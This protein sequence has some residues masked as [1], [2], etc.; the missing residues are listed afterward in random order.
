MLALELLLIPR[1]CPSS[2]QIELV[3]MNAIV[4]LLKITI[5]WLFLIPGIAVNFNAADKKRRDEFLKLVRSF[6]DFDQAQFLLHFQWNQN[7]ENF[8]E[9]YLWLFVFDTPNLVEVLFQLAGS[10]MKL[11]TDL[12]VAI[13]Q[14]AFLKKFMYG[15]KHIYVR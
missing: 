6:V 14:K 7:T 3:S 5:D 10:K 12:T 11:T 15:K 2:H 9:Y 1:Q 8:D 4:Y 13:Y